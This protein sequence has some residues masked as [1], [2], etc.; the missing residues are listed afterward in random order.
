MSIK[1]LPL[2]FPTNSD[3]LFIIFHNYEGLKRPNSPDAENKRYLE[4]LV[5]FSFLSKGKFLFSS[6]KNKK[7]EKKF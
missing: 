4:L 7:K 3:D 1:R 5:S 6:L 2:L